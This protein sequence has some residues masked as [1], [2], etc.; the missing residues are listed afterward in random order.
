MLTFEPVK[1]KTADNTGRADRRWR[2][3]RKCFRVG[4]VPPR[5]SQRI[6]EKMLTDMEDAMSA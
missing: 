5:D 3:C 2:E 4:W 1:I 6:E